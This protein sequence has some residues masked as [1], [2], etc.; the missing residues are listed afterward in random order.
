MIKRLTLLLL[1]LLAMGSFSGYLYLNNQIEIGE[2]KIAEGQKSIGAGEKALSAGKQ[3]LRAGKQKLQA[4]KQQLQIGKQKLAAGKKQYQIVRAIPLGA[5]SN[6]LPEATPLTGIVEHKI[7]EGG[8]QIAHGEKQVAYGEK[9]VAHGEKQIAAGE[10]KIRA[11]ELRLKS[12]K[13][14]IAQGIAKLEEAKKI[15]DALAISA[16]FFTFLT[17]VLAIF[18][19]RK[20]AL[21]S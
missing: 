3:R 20:R 7:R 9:Q 1:M 19:R 10:Q 8:K 15:R 18:W 11:G 17:I 21:R 4:G 13:I 6:L 14:A 2:A 16:A 12:G 5:V